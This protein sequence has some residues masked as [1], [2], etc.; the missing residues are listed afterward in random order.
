MRHAAVVAVGLA[1]L[2]GACSGGPPR[3]PANPAAVPDAVPRAEP[4][5]RYGNPPSYVVNGRRY[6]VLPT[7]RGYDERGVASWYGPDFDGG[8]TSSGERYDMYAMTAAHKTLPLPCY[9]RVTNL[10]NGRSVVVKVNDRGPFVDNRIIDLSYS[11]AAKLDMIRDGTA[12]VDVRAVGMDAAGGGAS[13]REQPSV[14]PEKRFYVQAG[15]FADAS[16]ARRLAARLAASGFNDVRVQPGRS[17]GRQL[18]KVRLGPLESVADF[19]S[20]VERLRASGFPDA[21]LA[22]D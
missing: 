3:R 11:A 20:I 4:R 6:A 17:G 1:V 12:L 2:L 10:Q 7:A 9:V 22:P 5:S 14:V 18:Y 16:N 19:D 8:R 15:A 13:P 21:I